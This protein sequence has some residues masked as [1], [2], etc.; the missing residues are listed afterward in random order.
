MFERIYA[1]RLKVDPRR[2]PPHATSYDAIRELYASKH[3]RTPYEQP[4]YFVAPA[5][6]AD[7]KAFFQSGCSGTTILGSAIPSPYVY[8]IMPF[9]NLLRYTSPRVLR[10]SDSLDS[11]W[12]KLVLAQATQRDWMPLSWFLDGNLTGPRGFTWWTP[13]DITLDVFASCHALGMPD[14]S[15]AERAV[16]LRRST[17]ST[18]KLD[19][20]V[21]TILDGFDNVVFCATTTESDPGIGR[22]ISL[23][24]IPLSL[25]ER[26]LVSPPV[27][28]SEISI[29]LASSSDHSA[30]P[31]RA[32]LLSLL[33]HLALFYE[34][35][36][37]A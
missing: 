31:H 8:R 18:R 14:D 11:N 9:P 7:A 33:P 32:D 10:L 28:V 26:E 1:A 19:G 34:S 12:S 17:L 35:L 37:C 15:I 36:D 4:S 3:L 13:V 21:P 16:V 22:A 30:H 5:D 25:G 20:F 29:Y 23:E 6:D 27:P 2:Q 24:A